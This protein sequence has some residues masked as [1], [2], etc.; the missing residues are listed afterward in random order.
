LL[1]QP[2]GQKL[3]NVRRQQIFFSIRPIL[4][5][6]Y[7]EILVSSNLNSKQL[8]FHCAHP[9]IYV[10]WGQ[11]IKLV[12]VASTSELLENQRNDLVFFK[13]I[14]S[15]FCRASEASKIDC[16]KNQVWK[17]WTKNFNSSLKNGYFGALI[18]QEIELIEH[19][20]YNF[21]TSWPQKISILKFYLLQKLLL[22]QWLKKC[23]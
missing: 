1:S 2:T 17:V 8:R 16:F 11:P 14:P 4:F 3:S 22:F 9:N 18:F 13:I 19:L 6:Y 21:K 20:K 23:L 12:Q 10:L 7:E 15:H 5:L